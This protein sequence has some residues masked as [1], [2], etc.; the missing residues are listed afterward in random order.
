MF[1]LANPIRERVCGAADALH[2]RAH[3][4]PLRLMLGF[5]FQI[6]PRRSFLDFRRVPFGPF[7]APTLSRI[8]VF[9]EVRAVHPAARRPE[10]TGH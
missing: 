8:G 5:V 1:D 3:R 10:S 9:A 6:H 2:D 7:H 4:Q